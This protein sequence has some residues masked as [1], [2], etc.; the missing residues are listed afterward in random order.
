M[1]MRGNRMQPNT[2]S[3]SRYLVMYGPDED[4]TGIK[5][6]RSD[7]PEEAIEAFL[8]W[9]RCENRYENGRKLSL[10]KKRIKA[11]IVDVGTPDETGGTDNAPPSS[12][13]HLTR[14]KAIK[15]NTTILAQ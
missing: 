11:L 6:I 7:A 3:F 4:G 10:S 8:E 5:G 12:P 15:N 14:P 9:Y 13:H 2:D 1:D